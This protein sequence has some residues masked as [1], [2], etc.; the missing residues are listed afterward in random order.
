MLNAFTV[1]TV[2]RALIAGGQTDQQIAA[3]LETMGIE[4]PNAAQ[5][6][7]TAPQAAVN[8]F[9]TTA[10]PLPAVPRFPTTAQATTPIQAGNGS[11]LMP[12]VKYVVKPAYRTAQ[13]LANAVKPGTRGFQ[14]ATQIMTYADGVTKR[15]LLTDLLTIDPSA[16]DGAVMSGI[17]GLQM[18]GVVESIALHAAPP[19]PAPVLT[20]PA[21][22]IDAQPQRRKYARKAAK[23]GK[24]P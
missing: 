16:T 13:A 14:I 2:V 15:K 24:R 23:R 3:T 12:A 18:R 5:P 20:V 7:A 4:S 6:I 19:V 1:V 21:A 9:P 11:P 17:H 10:D 8:R 22:V